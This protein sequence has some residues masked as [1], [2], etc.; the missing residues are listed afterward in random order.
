[1]KSHKIVKACQKTLTCFG[2]RNDT[3][4]GIGTRAY[5]TEDGY[6][7][8]IITTKECHQGF[9]GIIHGGIISTYF[10]EVLWHLHEL[11]GP[12]IVIMTLNEAVN[13]RIPVP[14]GVEIRVV[15][16]IEKTEGR[17]IT[18]AGKLILPDGSVAADCKILY[19]EI[20]KDPV[21]GLLIR[22]NTRIRKEFAEKDLE[23][24]D[25]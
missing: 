12:R 16:E 21:Q 19:L 7:V 11:V 8:G 15:G 23:A 10:D 25:F 24:I 18:A 22:E 17:K 6:V 1:M 5:L 2:C 4:E 20:R 3:T 13:F 14:V 9:P